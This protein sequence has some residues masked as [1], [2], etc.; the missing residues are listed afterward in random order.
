LREDARLH[1]AP[2]S[3]QLNEWNVQMKIPAILTVAAV[4][5]SATHVL[6]APP[7]S[8]DACLDKAFELAEQAANKKMD[9]KAA[10]K[11]EGLLSALEAK[12]AAGDLAGAEGAVKAVEDAIA[13]Q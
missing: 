13:K 7:A 9:K 8:K 5:V 12:C 11:V 2:S 1:A 6:A 3:F 10:G 4:L